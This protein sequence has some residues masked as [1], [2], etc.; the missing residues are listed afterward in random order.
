MEDM[1]DLKDRTVLVTGASRGIGAAAARHL[2]KLGAEVVLAAR[3]AEAVAALAAEIRG[4]G[5]RARSG[6]CDVADYAS[7][8]EAVGDGVDVLVN[9]AGLIE[10][11]A[12]IDESDPA[13][14]GRVIDVNLK[15]VYHCARAALPGMLAR[16][17]G[18]IVNISSGA[19]SSALE[20]W[21]H[22]CA[23]KAAVLS[24]TRCLDKEY[25][26][27]GIRVLGLS[28]GTVATEM[29]MSIKASG[30]NPV[31]RLDWSAH[32]PPEAVARAIAWLCTP[33][34]DAWRGHDFSLR[35]AEGR[36]AAGLPVEGA[37]A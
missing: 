27:T 17:S 11:I 36:A 35:T 26:D 12:R 30:M 24:L 18:T 2:A 25:R 14:W 13:A 7:V 1:A 28:P 33:D 16:G 9:N 37:S 4:A 15:G 22:Y 29:Q 31:S 34:A 32:I 5:G 20:G 21:S 3:S 6:A 8:A 23:S 19:A 10:P